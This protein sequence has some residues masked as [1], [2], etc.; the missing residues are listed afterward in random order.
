M[1]RGM[2]S[3]SQVFQTYI[4]DPGALSR[5]YL[6]RRSVPAPVELLAKKLAKLDRLILHV[7]FQGSLKLIDFFLDAIHYLRKIALE[8]LDLV[9]HQL[10]IAL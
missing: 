9:D 1:A 5:D 10:V 4:L 8:M 6:F 7:R 3:L 2:L